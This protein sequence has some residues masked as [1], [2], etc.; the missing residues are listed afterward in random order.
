[1]LP[2][3][4]Y[5]SYKRYKADTGTFVS[6]LVDTAKKCGYEANSQAD[7]AEVKGNTNAKPKS[8][9]SSDRQQKIS[10]RELS[11]VAETIANSAFE[12][13]AVVIATAKRAIALRKRCA[14]WFT[15]S[16]KTTSLDGSNEKHSHFIN[17]LE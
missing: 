17:V 1:M 7:P 15:S 8:T 3:F 9:P 11:V 6:W 14:K 2:K 12:V 5:S 16:Q 13:P 4:L 10:L